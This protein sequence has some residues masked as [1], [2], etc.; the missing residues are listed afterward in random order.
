MWRR[1]SLLLLVAACSS[2]ITTSGGAGGGGAGGGGG[3]G[4]DA[5]AGGAAGGG[6][7]GAGGAGASA[8]SGGAGASSGGGGA[9]GDPCAACVG[10]GELCKNGACVTD[11]TDPASAPCDPGTVCNVSEAAPKQ[12]VPEGSP[13]TIAGPGVACGAVTCGAGTLCDPVAGACSPDLPCLG[14]SLV[15]DTYFGAACSCARPPPSCAAADLAALNGAAFMTGLV[16]LDFDLTCGAWGVTV[17]SGPDYLRHMLPDGTWSPTT[18]VANLNMG[19]VAAAQGSNGTFG[20]SDVEV[21]LTYNCCANCGCAANPP[22]GVAWFDQVQGTLPMVIPS[23]AFTT[24]AG[25]FGS[26]YLDTGPQGLT[27]GLFFDVYV[28][29]VQANG[30]LWR[31]SLQN[32]IAAPVAD[33]GS[34]VYAS[35]AFDAARLLVATEAGDLVFVNT[36]SGLTSLF[37]SGVADVTSLARDPWNGRVYVATKGGAI[38][39]FAS[40]GADLG[41]F[42]QASGSGRISLARDNFL[43]HLVSTPIQVASV[44]RF[45]LPSDP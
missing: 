18:G 7:G 14:M 39:A 10:P 23:P 8:G 25:P 2:E 45:A 26:G 43:Y 33:L 3:S 44:E 29:N 32:Q 30:D 11:C 21:A 42:A 35:T 41:L 1:S 31:V 12:C 40:D 15:G 28:G 24:G 16:D 22:Q 19:E 17:V 27:L 4:G 20:G 13:C 6:A 9:G 38:E 37:A 5:G 36:T 34:R